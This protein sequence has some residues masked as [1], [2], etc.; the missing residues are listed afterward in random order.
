MVQVALVDDW[1]VEVTDEEVRARA[2]PGFAMRSRFRRRRRH[3]RYLKA[4][5]I[6]DISPGSGGATSSPRSAARARRS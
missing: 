5:R 6:F 1:R 4:L 2:A 3:A